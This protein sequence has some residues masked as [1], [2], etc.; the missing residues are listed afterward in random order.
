[1]AQ[2]AKGINVATQSYDP[3]T[4]RPKV[5]LEESKMA[6]GIMS[7]LIMS[8]LTFAYVTLQGQE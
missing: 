6:K 2:K 5:T 1:M 4:S 8:C 7:C 3:A